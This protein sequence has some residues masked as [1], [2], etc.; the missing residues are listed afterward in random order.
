MPGMKPIR[1]GIVGTGGMAAAHARYFRAAGGVELASCYDIDPARC[2][3]YAAAH[4]VGHVAASLDELIDAVEAVSVVTSDA[5]HAPVAL[6]ALKA[7]RH[8]FCE[9]PLTVTLGEARRVARAYARARRRGAIGMT[10]FSH[11][12]AHFDLARRIVARGDLG[13]LRYV[14]AHYLQGGLAVKGAWQASK[15]IWRLQTARGSAGVLG[16]LGCHLLD[17]VTGIC[18]PAAAVRCTLRTHTKIGADGRRYT[19]WQGVALDANDTAAV[20]VDFAGGAFGHC[21]T[22]RWAGGHR[23]DV[24]LEV[25]GTDGALS[26][27]HT[28]PEKPFC[29]ICRGRAIKKWEWKDLPVPAFVS[30]WQRFVR[31]IRR[32]TPAQP[33]IFRGAEIQALLDA[34]HRSAAGEKRIAPPT[35][36]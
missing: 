14:R 9:K 32:G 30:N 3:A 20:D 31:A 27:G 7:G 33:D 36:R 17:F 10:N 29:R 19:R 6:R 1:I 21:Q 24:L 4:G 22:T 5:A 35:W 2:A 26:L 23:N 18:G 8:V 25:H 13:E 34:C 11:R 15:A 12:G 16:D 28:F